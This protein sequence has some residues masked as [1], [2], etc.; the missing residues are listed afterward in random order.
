[1]G[2][3]YLEDGTMVDYKEYINSHPHWQKVRKAR[4]DFDQHLCVVCRR[5]LTGEPYQTHHLSYQRLGRERL[6]DVVTMCDSCHHVF[7]Q[8]WVKSA[9]WEGKQEGHWEIYDLQHTARLCARYWKEDRLICREEDA[10]NCCNR[11]VAAQLIDK[12]FKESGLTNHPIIDPNDISLFIR[13]K[14]YELFF[15]AEDR[16]LTVEGFLDEYYGKKARGKNPLRQ[17]AGRKNGPFDHEPKAFHR[18]YG[19]NKNINILM[20]EVKK[21]EQT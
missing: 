7:H 20:E 8:N 12:Y 17:E 19:E 1:M 21:Y 3:A 18:H 10:L 15:E 6:R 2:L 14:R 16:G 4:Y 13:N 5:D 9:F 11:E